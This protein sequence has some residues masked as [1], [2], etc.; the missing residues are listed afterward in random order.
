LV[1]MTPGRCC[2]V[3]SAAVLVAGCS[4][5]ASVIFLCCG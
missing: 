3:K 1:S 2:F 5:G 4:G